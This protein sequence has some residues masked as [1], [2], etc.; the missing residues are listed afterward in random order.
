MTEFLRSRITIY[1]RRR[2][3]LDV[4]SYVITTTNNINC[5]TRMCNCQEF[6]SWYF[7]AK[8]RVS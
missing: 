7:G 5:R 2:I 1:L 6:K 3:V 8:L 4:V